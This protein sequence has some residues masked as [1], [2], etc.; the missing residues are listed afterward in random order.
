M[1]VLRH[2]ALPAVCRDVATIAER[3]F[4]DAEAAM[5]QCRRRAMRPAA[6]MAAIY[7]A[8]LSALVRSGWRDPA[9]RVSLSKPLKLWLVLR[10][11]F[12]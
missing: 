8:T 7:G 12:L 4:R 9:E 10:H 6:V 2:L 5:A 1:A 3:H 11:G